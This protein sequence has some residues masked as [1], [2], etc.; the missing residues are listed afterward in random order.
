MTSS[1]E[2]GSL[3]PHDAM[4]SR[5]GSPSGSA[6]RRSPTSQVARPQQ[7]F[8]PQPPAG[9]SQPPNSIASGGWDSGGWG[10]KRLPR[11]YFAGKIG[12]TDWRHTLGADL[13]DGEFGE[14]VRCER[15]IYCGP[16]FVACDHGCSHGDCTHGLGHGCGANPVPPRWL[17]PSLCLEWIRRCDLFFAWIDDPTCYGTLVEIG[18]AQLMRKPVYIGFKSSWHYSEMWFAAMGPR[19]IARI[20][21]SAAE[22]LER[23]LAYGA[24]TL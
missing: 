5:N 8:P 14:P 19:T 1:N 2:H 17:V 4:A 20:H 7:P 13:W 12:H 15:F 18:W 9:T 11:L 3:K 10:G 21:T 23:A 6:P 24:A 22:A 16:F